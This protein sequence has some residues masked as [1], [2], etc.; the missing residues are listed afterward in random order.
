[1][2]DTTIQ[3]IDIGMLKGD[4]N[5]VTIKVSTGFCDGSHTLTYYLDE[6]KYGESEIQIQTHKHPWGD[7]LKTRVCDPEDYASDIIEA[8]GAAAD[9]LMKRQLDDPDD[10]HETAP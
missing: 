7:G 8:R 6:V 2:S 9:E 10:W 4:I 1:M 3:S 5:G